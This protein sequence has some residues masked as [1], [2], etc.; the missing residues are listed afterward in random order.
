MANPI[1]RITGV[2]GLIMMGAISYQVVVGHL[3]MV[4]AGQ[5]AAITLVAVIVVRRLGDFGMR[6]LAGSMERQAATPKRR[7]TDAVEEPV[8]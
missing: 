5:R 6:A 2:L 8:G 3:A 1:S 4:Q 7:R